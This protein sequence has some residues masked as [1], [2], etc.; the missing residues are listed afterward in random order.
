MKILIVQDFLR[1]GGTERQSCLLANAFSC[2]GHTVALMT[3]RPGGA[4]DAMPSPRVERLV[5]QSLDTGC[6]W[7]APMLI[8]KTREWAPD[9]V[10]CMG[11][12]ANCR[13]GGLAAALPSARVV[14]TLRTGKPLPWLFRR[15]LARVA[16]VV[17]NSA[18]SHATLLSQHRVPPERASVIRNALVFSPDAIDGATASAGRTRRRKREAAGSNCLVMLCTAMFRPEKNQRELIEIVARLPRETSWQLWFA[19]DGVTRDECIALVNQ[20]G[21]SDQVKFFGFQ[22]NPT[23]L[24]RAADIAVLTSTRESLSN[25]LIESHAHGL[26]S[27]AYDVTG[28]RECGGIIVPRGDRN[29]FLTALTRLMSDKSAL[30]AE[31]ARVRDFARKHF[32]PELQTVACLE[33]FNRLCQTPS[34]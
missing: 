19:G 26:P 8:R 32:S 21:L 29:A 6:D 1:N 2:A 15:S 20:K 27:V 10:L 34:P 4:L 16:H 30:A 25:F 22:E 14:C 28:A 17:A 5:L 9:I 24:Y 23:E 3:F 7:F 13:G 11:R 18:E 12:M 31:G 33:L